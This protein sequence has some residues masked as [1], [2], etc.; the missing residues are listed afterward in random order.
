MLVQRRALCFSH[1]PP[2]AQNAMTT[3]TRRSRLF[4]R[5]VLLLPLFAGISLSASGCGWVRSWFVEDRTE[6]LVP[7]YSTA[8]EQYNFAE[9]QRQL[10][11]PSSLEERRKEQ[12]NKIIAVYEAVED[13]FPEDREFTPLARVKLGVL[14]QGRPERESKQKAIDYFQ[15]CQQL[16]PEDDHILA[17]S[18]LKEGITLDTLGRFESAQAKYRE[19]F[20]RFGQSGDPELRVLSNEARSLYNKVHT[21]SSVAGF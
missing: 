7:E 13:R 20:E 18:L 9:Y 17:F 3:T 5:L 4:V 2:L 1:A 6:F 19:V 11:T 14:W 8:R 10:T 12:M 21:R 16:Y 15:L